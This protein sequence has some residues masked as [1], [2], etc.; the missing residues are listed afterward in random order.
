MKV[1]GSLFT[2]TSVR[3]GSSW[4]ATQVRDCFA[5]RL[6]CTLARREDTHRLWIL[7]EAHIHLVHSREVLHIG[8]E[9]IDFDAI[10]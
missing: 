9:D 6:G 3:M 4:T 5:I 10:L 7:E 1:L 8:Q 2:S